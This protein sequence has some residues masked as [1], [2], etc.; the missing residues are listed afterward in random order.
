MGKKRVSYRTQVIPI[1]EIH[2]RHISF[3][4]QHGIVAKPALFN[5]FTKSIATSFNVLLLI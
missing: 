3:L 5:I 4:Q 1:I 2:R